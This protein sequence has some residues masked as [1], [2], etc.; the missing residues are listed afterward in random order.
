MKAKNTSLLLTVLLSVR[1]FTSSAQ[2]SLSIFQRLQKLGEHTTVLYIAAHPDDENTHL[3]AWL[4]QEKKFRTAYMALTRGDGGQNLIGSELGVDLGLIRTREL[5]AARSIDGGEQYFSRAFD[6]GFSKRPEETLNIWDRNK[7]LED[8]VRVIR[9][10]KPDLIICRFPPDQRAG[11]GHHSSSAILAHE[12]FLAAADPAQF[13]GIPAHDA[14]W[15]ANAIFWNSFTY[16]NPAEAPKTRFKVE[17]GGYDP[18]SGKSYGELAA[19][20]RSQHK[21]QGFGVPMERNPHTEYFI[22]VDGD[23]MNADLFS[24]KDRYFEMSPEGRLIKSKIENAIAAFDPFHPEKS[25]IS[26]LDLYH[27]MS[28]WNVDSTFRE[29]KLNDLKEVIIDCMGLWTAVYASEESFAVDDTIPASLQLI[30]RNNDGLRIEIPSYHLITGD[31]ILN[32][33]KMQ[34]YRQSI[35]LKGCK[36]TTQPYWLHSEHQRGMFV[37]EDKSMIGRPWNDPAINLPVIIHYGKYSLPFNIPV[38]YKLIDPVKGEMERP[39]VITQALTA[40]MNETVSIYNTTAPRTYKLNLTWHRTHSDSVT[41][42]IVRPTGNNWSV[43]CNDTT[44]FFSKKGENHIVNFL[45]RPESMINSVNELKFTYTE[46]SDHLKRPLGS[47]REIN[48]PHIPKITWFPALTLKLISADIKVNAKKVLYIKGAG[49]DVAAMIRQL[50]IIVDEISA[51][52]LDDIQ[53]SNYDAVVTGIR[54]YNTDPSLSGF[55]DKITNYLQNGGVFLIQYNTNNNLHPVTF[56]T[57]AP[58][59]IGRNRVTEED[60]EVVFS[61]PEDPILKTPNTITAGDFQN[62]VQERGLYFASDIDNRYRQ[63]LSM[64][65]QGEENQ[66]GSLILL[67]VGK[68]KYIYTGLSFFR[69]LP[70]GVPGAFRL[71]ANL[72]SRP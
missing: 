29:R 30:V 57:P 34:Y 61:N 48:Y 54:A 47:Q 69:Q 32:A 35:T 37:V 26:L 62:W 65:D 42:K 27:E 40:T 28:N 25:T 11:H 21:S 53:L 51:A 8:I 4:S 39:L 16:G 17:I 70:A 20:S 49:D 6:F 18:V 55:F 41:I 45:I 66:P 13:P 14:S 24:L 22:P 71:F 56:T 50:G 9:T 2:S 64:H 38:Q 23:T 5:M 12:A 19:E 31:T 44:I 33:D 63:P 59:L 67:P 52:A 10:V 1:L 60:A 7:V 46:S 72:I 43:N 15:K 3:I 68:G 36:G 58:F